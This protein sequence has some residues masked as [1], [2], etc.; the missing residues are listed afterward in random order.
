MGMG[1]AAGTERDG[2]V[3][4]TRRDDLEVDEDSRVE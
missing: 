2:R 1:F 4:E 3:S